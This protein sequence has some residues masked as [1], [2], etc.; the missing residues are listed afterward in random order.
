MSLNIWNYNEPWEAR[1]QLIAACI[2]RAA[3]DLIGLQEIRLERDRSPADQARQIA[4]LL[5]E[6]YHR[7]YRGAMTFDRAP[8]RE[9]GAGREEGLALLSRWPLASCDALALTRDAA[10]DADHHQRIVLHAEIRTPAG[11][12]RFCNTHW[13]L[14]EQ[15]RARNAAQTRALIARLARLAPV[16]LVGDLNSLPDGAG[17]RG[18]FGPAPSGERPPCDAWAELHPDQ[19]GFTFRSDN[20]S[21]RIDYIAYDLSNGRFGRALDVQLAC[22]DAADGV[23]PSDHLGL[24]ADFEIKGAA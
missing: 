3:P 8:R 12:V 2:D 5:R 17:A 4:G 22:G 9:P 6:Q 7:A 20:P 24:T 11:A 16:I 14:S 15:A 23:Y 19:P 10:D 21:R 13:S 18:L 1:R